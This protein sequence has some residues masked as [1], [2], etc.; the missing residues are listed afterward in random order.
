MADLRAITLQK[1]LESPVLFQSSQDV[2]L[3][4]RISCVSFHI[5]GDETLLLGGLKKRLQ[6]LV[7][8]PSLSRSV[9]KH[10]LLFLMAHL[11]FSRPD[12]FTITHL[13][14]LQPLIARLCLS[15]NSKKIPKVVV[16]FGETIE[17]LRDKKS[18]PPALPLCRRLHPDFSSFFSEAHQSLDVGN[19]RFEDLDD[20]M[21]A[22]TL[23]SWARTL[24]SPITPRS[25]VMFVRLPNADTADNQSV[26]RLIHHFNTLSKWVV[27]SVLSLSSSREAMVSHICKFLDIAELC[28]SWNDFHT[29]F[30]LNSGLNRSAIYRLSLVWKSPQLTSHSFLHSLKGL[31]SSSSNYAQYRQALAAVPADQPCQPFL[32]IILGDMT[33][34]Q[35]AIPDTFGSHARQTALYNF[36]KLKWFF[37]ITQSSWE[38]FL[39]FPY[40]IVPDHTCASYLAS[41]TT[42]EQIFT[43]DYLYQLSKV[44][45]AAFVDTKPKQAGAKLGNLAFGS[46]SIS[47][48]SLKARQ[49]VGSPM[50]LWDCV[51]DYAATPIRSVE[52]PQKSSRV[53][54]TT[55]LLTNTVRRLKKE[56]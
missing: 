5:W 48:I 44:R 18:P 45:E 12:S 34:I 6:D 21:L 54:G 37:A 11:Q 16:H 35:N 36:T 19:W 17:A 23:T 13:S 50:G 3:L 56:R 22:Q 14:D 39:R 7:D 53:T 43:E 8:S 2:S 27:S 20:L 25:L 26:R 32:A 46:L 47:T 10:H 1:L 42:C 41:I 9:L 30:A 51:P 15:T 33:N 29:A 52:P 49:D 55:S 4:G 28:L 38:R 24:A 31:A 40:L